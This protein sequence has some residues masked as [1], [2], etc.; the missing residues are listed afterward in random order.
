MALLLNILNI[1]EIITFIYL[2]FAGVYIFIYSLA[3]KLKRTVDFPESEQKRKFAILIP[4]YKEDIVIV[5]VAKEALKQDYPEDKFDVIIIADSFQPETL[6]EL[7]KL[8]LQVV[9]VS[10]KNSTKSKALNKAMEFIGDTYEIALILDADNIMKHDLIYKLNNAFDKGY[11]AIQAHRIAKNTNNSLALLDAISEEINNHIFRKGH[12]AM[13]LSSALIGSGMAFDYSFFKKM[14]A[15]VKAIGG[16]DKE[17]EL[18]IL[19]D[20]IKIEYLD[21]AYVLDEKV[22][23]SDAFAKQRKRWLSAQFIYFGRFFKEGIIQLFTK[24][25]IDFID[26][27]YQMIQPPRILLLGLLGII[28]AFRGVL[29]IFDVSNSSILLLSFSQWLSI[30]IITIIAFILA[31]PKKYYNI[32]TIYA[33]GSLPRSFLTMFLS[34][35]RLKGA[36]KSFLHTKHGTTSE[37]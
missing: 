11:K 4:G 28:T 32:K 36:N 7:R 10:F 1:L 3:G 16:F 5:D 20:S 22:Q 2:A 19:K 17:L 33:L 14:M 21:N 34:L 26:K 31:F 18:K 12:R 35:F 29:L 25:N 9:E 23:K 13:G 24:F 37:K 27:L 8:P 30:F 6:E 15:E